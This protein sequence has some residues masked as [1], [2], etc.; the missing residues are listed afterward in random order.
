M[1]PQPPGEAGPAGPSDRLERVL[2]LIRHLRVHCPWDADQTAASLVPHLLEE[3]Q[4]VA[5]AVRSGAPPPDLARELGDLLLNVAYQIVMAEEAGAF[6]AED[7][8]AELERKMVRRHP[9]VDWEDFSSRLARL[10]R[11]DGSAAPGVGEPGAGGS[12][13]AAAAGP[14]EPG[15]G[16][17]A[18]ADATG[19]GEPGAGGSAY[20]DATGGGPASAASWERRKAAERRPGASVL[21]GLAR[22]LDPLT[23]AHR[24]QE[25]VAAV[26][27]DWDD[28]DG[29]A[30]KVAEELAEARDALA[31][32]RAGEG[33]AEAG[34]EGLAEAARKGSAK[35]AEEELAPAAAEELAEAA[36]EELGDLLFA[37]VNL[38]RRA[39]VHP[40][41]A[42]AVANAKFERRFRALEAL[43]AGEGR[44]AGDL[45]LAELDAL[46]DRVKA[47][48]ALGA[49]HAARDERDDSG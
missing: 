14:G 24:M 27:F 6:D 11:P 42:L 15:A 17:S 35:C 22:G 37:V 12:A 28:L 20:A 48:E 49:A 21:H 5:D 4:E 7:V 40:T 39:G 43:L 3:A 18:G 2:A 19:A 25:R 33:S 46:W 31:R 8:T 47:A 9:H 29:P 16:G 13:Y 10:V 30:D 34:A 36:E 45:P 26:G 23:R 38:A 32:R 44:A 41:N 1:T